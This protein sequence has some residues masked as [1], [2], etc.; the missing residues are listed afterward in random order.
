MVLFE[1]VFDVPGANEKEKG[2]GVWS[3]ILPGLVLVH[4]TASD[5]IASISPFSI[6]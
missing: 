3:V 6:F 1:L 5:T 2:P 4:L